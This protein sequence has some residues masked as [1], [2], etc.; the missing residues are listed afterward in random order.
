MK[1]RI[2]E[3]L[4]SSD[5]NLTNDEINWAIENLPDDAPPP[6]AYD[7]ARDN[8]FEA[9]GIFQ[10]DSEELR[11]EYYKIRESIGTS[12]SVRHSEIVQT[13]IQCGSPKLVRSFIVRGVADYES[14]KKQDLFNFLRKMFEDKK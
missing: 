11:K 13:L 3:A 9:C 10:Q 2:L 5:N 12:N 8:I 7:H 1:H 6:V 4:L 14:D